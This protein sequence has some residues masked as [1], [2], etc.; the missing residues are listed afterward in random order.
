MFLA[1]YGTSCST[2]GDCASGKCNDD[3]RCG[4]A[5]GFQFMEKPK[6][7]GCKA[8]WGERCERSEDC[9]D[10]NAVC[11]NFIC[12]CAAAYEYNKIR[13]VC[14][15][16]DDCAS[17]PCQNNGTCINHIGR[18][19]CEC[20]ELFAG[21]ECHISTDHCRSKECKNGGTCQNLENYGACLCLRGYIG[22]N[23]QVVAPIALRDLVQVELE[24]KLE[25]P[26]HDEGFRSTIGKGLASAVEFAYCRNRSLRTECVRLRSKRMATIQSYGNWTVQE[27]AF[28]LQ[29]KVSAMPS[30]ASH[31]P[32]SDHLCW[33]RSVLSNNQR[34]HLTGKVLETSLEYRLARAVAAALLIYEQ[35]LYDSSDVKITP[36]GAYRNVSVKV[37]ALKTFQGNETLEV[38]YYAAIDG[39]C[40]SA[41]EMSALISRIGVK[42]FT[43]H[44]LEQPVILAE[45]YNQ[46]ELF[47]EEE[48]AHA[49]VIIT[50]MSET[51]NIMTISFWKNMEERLTKL[52][53]YILNSNDLP[54]SDSEIHSPSSNL[55]TCKLMKIER[56]NMSSTV[57]LVLHTKKQ[58]DFLNPYDMVELL[59]ATDDQEIAIHLRTII[60]RT[61][62]AYGWSFSTIL[63]HSTNLAFFQLH[64][65]PKSDD[66]CQYA[67]VTNYLHAAVISSAVLQHHLFATQPTSD[68]TAST[69]TIPSKIAHVTIRST[70]NPAITP[71]TTPITAFSTAT[72]TF[73]TTST[74]SS[75]STPST[76]STGTT[77]TRTTISTPVPSLTTIPQRLAP[78][79]TSEEPLSVV[80][81]EIFSSSDYV[82]VGSFCQDHYRSPYPSHSKR[83][84]IRTVTRV[85]LEQSVE[86]KNFFKDT[87]KRLTSLL[88]QA[89]ARQRQ[90]E[91]NLLIC[92][93][94]E[95]I[96]RVNSTSGLTEI[97]YYALMNGQPVRA[98]TLVRLLQG[99]EVQ[100]LAVALSQVIYIKAEVYGQDHSSSSQLEVSSGKE[101]L[102]AFLENYVETLN[103]KTSLKVVMTTCGNAPAKVVLETRVTYVQRRTVVLH[104]SQPTTVIVSPSLMLLGTERAHKSLR[105]SSDTDILVTAYNQEYLS[106]DGYSVLPVPRLGKRYHVMSYWPSSLH[107][108]LALVAIQDNTKVIVELSRFTD[109]PRLNGDPIDSGREII[110][111]R[112]ESL[113]IQSMVDLSGTRILSDKPLAAY[114]G[115]ICTN[116]KGKSR[117]HIADQLVPDEYLGKSFIFI[118]Y[119][120]GLSQGSL[121]KVLAIENET[122]VYDPSREQDIRLDRAGDTETLS[123]PIGSED[124]G[125]EGHFMFSNKPIIMAQFSYSAGVDMESSL[126][127]PSMSLVSPMS[128]YHSRYRF[129]LP[130]QDQLV[131]SVRLAIEDP[132]Y[133]GLRLNNKRITSK[134]WLPV[135]G[136]APLIVIAALKLL[137]GVYSLHHENPSMTFYLHLYGAA[138][139][140]SYSHL[141]GSCSHLFDYKDGGGSNTILEFS[142]LDI[143]H[144]K[145]HTTPIS[146]ASSTTPITTPTT[147]TSTTSTTTTTTTTS[148][149][150]TTP[151]TT[152]TTTT[153]T[154]VTTI[155]TTTKPTTVPNTTKAPKRT[156]RHSRRNKKTSTDPD[157]GSSSSAAQRETSSTEPALSTLRVT[158]TEY[159]NN[160]STNSIN[161]TIHPTLPLGAITSRFWLAMTV[162]AD[163]KFIKTVQ[164]A[165]ETRLLELYLSA[166]QIRGVK[167]DRMRRFASNG[168]YQLQIVTCKEVNEQYCD[169]IFYLTFNERELDPDA[170][171]RIYSRLTTNYLISN[172]HEVVVYSHIRAY[173]ES[174]STA[175]ASFTMET[176]KYNGTGELGEQVDPGL[177][178]SDGPFSTIGWV[179]GAVSL[180]CLLMATAFFTLKYTVS[181]NKNS[182]TWIQRRLS[183]DIE[184]GKGESKSPESSKNGSDDDSKQSEHSDKSPG[185]TEVRKKS[186]TPAVSKKRRKSSKKIMELNESSSDDEESVSEAKYAK[187]ELNNHLQILNQLAEQAAEARDAE[188]GAAQLHLINSMDKAKNK[189][190][191]RRKAKLQK[192][193]A[194]T[195]VKRPLPVLNS[196]D[197][198]NTG[199]Q[200]SSQARSK[201]VVT[202]GGA[203]LP[204]NNS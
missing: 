55:I 137:P 25:T 199:S 12:S 36:K 87:N 115:N 147:T 140:Q 109:L 59:R 179:M 122:V 9:Y 153:T 50:E 38:I 80:S 156:R 102:V 1:S 117:D 42:Q 191:L 121:I 37:L 27:L 141:A 105:I 184:G 72:A 23:C 106:Q 6:G 82:M 189:D 100:E 119:S 198:S 83:Y 91:R 111:K 49:F 2:G 30:V 172:I 54:S 60:N 104:P 201:K 123:F 18:Y 132:E 7:A 168:P 188:E 193:R 62:V 196:N 69:S 185:S 200:N 175:V 66:F 71:I 167:V 10:G 124:F 187:D 170:T 46:T 4:C 47:T 78:S 150:T 146:S 136:T 180:T 154:P 88:S 134:D 74:T 157:V 131:H 174:S 151:T 195:K 15:D 152:T 181:S 52:M 194:K 24:V 112:Y 90:E 20:P 155:T 127:D 48:Y 149:T 138:P 186:S 3:R 53:V 63:L 159:T 135:A 145:L 44:T 22:S 165:L 13:E 81:L 77:T 120:E 133:E 176:D 130:A 128:R 14:Q 68:S 108:Q 182:M 57:N 85:P 33:M 8:L 202:F 164:I 116:I 93:K 139:H 16:V 183:K 94:I 70:S 45:P 125:N 162:E 113:Q 32:G 144:S 67:I 73:T 161:S 29:H 171:E 89:F 197:N 103:N 101:F 35:S 84:W 76:A 51:I 31:T 65:S 148:T 5:S 58:D 107:S 21:R 114:S 99:Y 61:T 98:V 160:K 97:I 169:L 39:S 203:E 34:S 126:G 92:A 28:R 163:E 95:R 56:V 40:F 129:T 190:K 142:T 96:A 192:Q 86:D 41:K 177:A 158:T 166:L 204:P 178:D 43:H 17:T 64:H 173:K 79:P 110:M 143:S 11:D 75:T 118:T 19:R 26:V